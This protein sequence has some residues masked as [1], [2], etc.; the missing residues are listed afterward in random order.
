MTL[1]ER[2]LFDSKSAQLELLDNMK[3]LEDKIKIYE[4]EME[5]LLNKKRIEMD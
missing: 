3:E 2:D 1:H 5:Q 4:L